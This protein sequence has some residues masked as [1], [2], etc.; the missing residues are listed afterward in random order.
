MQERRGCFSRYPEQACNLF[1]LCVHLK[2]PPRTIRFEPGCI[3]PLPHHHRFYT[4]RALRRFG[5][6]VPF[7]FFY[8]SAVVFKR[9]VLFCVGARGCIR[10][11]APVSHQELERNEESPW[12][13]RGQVD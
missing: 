3:S 5:P 12:K 9:K 11:G 8:L 4:S 6:P 2:N 7:N 13:I 10:I 1:S